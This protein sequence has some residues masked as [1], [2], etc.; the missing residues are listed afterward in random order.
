MRLRVVG[1]NVLVGGGMGRTSG[2]K[3]TFPHLAQPLCFVEPDEVV[4]AAEAVVK[5]F[6]DHHCPSFLE[7]SEHP[8]VSCDEI[9]KALKLKAA[10]STVLDQ[11][12]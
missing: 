11:M 5:F 7:Y 10:F 6:R 8:Y 12:Q 1:Y 2:N 3:N 4:A 9:K